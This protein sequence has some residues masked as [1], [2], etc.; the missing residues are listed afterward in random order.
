MFKKV[1][2]RF[3]GRLVAL[4]LLVCVGAFFGAV[5]AFA[6]DAANNTSFIARYEQQAQTEALLLQKVQIVNKSGVS[7]SSFL[8]T[9]DS[10]NQQIAALYVVQEE[11]AGARATL[12][13]SLDV[14]GDLSNLQAERE[15]IV[16]T[17]A[18]ETS[19]LQAATAP[20]MKKSLRSQLARNHRELLRVNAELS[21]LQETAT[22]F[23]SHPF[24]GGLTQLD[25]SILRL[26]TALIAYTNAWLS[27]HSLS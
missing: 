24:A 5:Q 1:P 17:I 14:Q 8:T 12:T 22:R 26:Q 2:S 18:Q 20:A 9:A 19:S 11:L 21:H 15:A 16:S 23:R 4:S 27:G 3:T 25:S 13:T 6:A 7:D 10:F